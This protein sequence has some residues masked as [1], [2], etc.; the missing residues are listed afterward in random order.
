MHKRIKNGTPDLVLSDITL[1]Y[2]DGYQFYNKVRSEFFMLNLPFL[3]LTERTDDQQF[4]YA[5]ELGADYFIKN[6]ILV[7][8]Y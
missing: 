5:M 7:M 2:I 6:H 3:F 4:N 1:L 8:N